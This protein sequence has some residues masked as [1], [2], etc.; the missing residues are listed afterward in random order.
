MPLVPEPA[1][2]AA[3]C[4]QVL[5]RF[6]WQHMQPGARPIPPAPPPFDITQSCVHAKHSSPSHPEVGS[7][8]AVGNASAHQEHKTMDV[9]CNN[10]LCFGGSSRGAFHPMRVGLV[11]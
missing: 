10:G 11:V 2:L 1:R 9:A 5:A 6:R 3:I 7:A 8:V 4:L